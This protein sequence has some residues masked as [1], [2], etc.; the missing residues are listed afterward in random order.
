MI[1]GFHL[2]TSERLVSLKFSQRQLYSGFPLSTLFQS[3][4]L[5]LYIAYREIHY[6]I[7]EQNK[8]GQQI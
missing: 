7:G 2:K 8:W 5:A 3:G 6:H 1:H 4:F